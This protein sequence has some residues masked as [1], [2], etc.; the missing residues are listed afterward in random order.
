MNLLNILKLFVNKA[1]AERVFSDKINNLAQ[2]C[3]DITMVTCEQGC[4]PFAFL[5]H[6]SA[7]HVDLD[8][9]FSKDKQQP[10]KIVYVYHSIALWGGVERIFVDKMN[11]LANVYGY[12]VYILTYNQGSH[13]IPFAVSPKVHYEDL[14]VCIHYQYHYHGPRRYWECFVRQQRLRR[15]LKAKFHEINPDV[16][17]TTTAEMMPFQNKIRG[18]AA[19]IAESHSD[20]DHVIEFDHQNW[21]HWIQQRR[22]YR[23]LKHVDMV[24]VLTEADAWRWRTLTGHVVAIPNIV[25]LNKTEKYSDHEQKRAIFVGRFAKQKAIPNLLAAWQL[26]HQRHPDWQLDMY[27]NG[28]YKDYYVKAIAALNANIMVHEPTKEI[29]DKYC[30]SSM[31]LLTSL[32]EPFG[33][34]IPE[35]MSCGLPVVSFE[36]D[37]PCSIITDGSDGFIVKNRSIESFADRVCQLIE[38][39]DLRRRMGQV[40]VVSAQRYSADK[41]MPLWKELF[42]SLVKE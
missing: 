8:T 34:V 28:E 18:G 41:I 13:E 19:L 37:G 20:F 38:D 36:G 7:H 42:E 17:I 35:A 14:G 39:Q 22:R 12:E 27:G 30:Q 15:L 11:Y 2:R 33:L 9:R 29:A 5:M 25:H 40:A 16:I 32:Y 1:G 10:M 26:V 23:L 3:Y 24:V 21:R 6:D 4:H 31:L